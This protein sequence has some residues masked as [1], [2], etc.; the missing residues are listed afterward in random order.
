MLYDII[1]NTRELA[2]YVVDEKQRTNN[3]QREKRKKAQREK[4]RRSRQMMTPFTT[5][6]CDVSYVTIE[7]NGRTYS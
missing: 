1:V 3:Q 4:E 7:T 5:F 2:M 6:L